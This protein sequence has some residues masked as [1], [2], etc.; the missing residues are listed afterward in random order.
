MPGTLTAGITPTEQ[1]LTELCGRSFLRLWSYANPYKDDGH[2]F[3]DLLAV[4]GNHVFIFFDREKQLADLTE[5]ADPQVLW[6]R[7]KRGAIDRQVNTAHGAERYLRSGRKIYLD[8]KK[9]KEFPV[10]LDIEAMTVHKIIVAHGAAQACKDFAESNI[11]GSLAICYGEPDAPQ[12]WP[13]MIHLD[14]KAPIHVFDSYNLPIILGELDTIKD[15]ADYLDAKARA[16]SSLDML[17][18]CGEEDLLAHYLLNLD[19]V[20]K[21]HYIG[22]T[23]PDV[24]AVM[25]GEGEWRD[26]I[27]LPQY[28]ETK[29]ANRQSYLWDEIIQRTCDNWLAGKLLGDGELLGGRGAIQEMAKEP[30]FMRRAIAQH[31]G[32]AIAAFPDAKGKPTRHLRFFNSY[33]PDKGYVFLQLW[34]P[35]DMRGDDEI[36]RAKRQEILR[37][38]CGVAK[39]RHLHLKTVVG[40]CI[41]PPRLEREVGEDFV[42]LDCQDWPDEAR[43]E[44]DDLN[45]DWHFFETGLCHERRIREFVLPPTPATE[46]ANPIKKKI[47]RNEPCPCGSGKKFKRCHGS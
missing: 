4:F 42:W 32:E 35:P 25:I 33:Y 3:C 18:Y 29:R 5:E 6:E 26:F 17:S 47:G 44:Y 37:I 45:E 28:E 36:Y 2:E 16:I 7:W 27:A 46:R 10:P 19:S 34:I 8:A 22:T 24:N 40:I 14:K 15:F 30:R 12:S 38:A 11:Y 21:K 20:N 31:M 39:N 23:D 41:P 1:F 13:F 9:G 43:A